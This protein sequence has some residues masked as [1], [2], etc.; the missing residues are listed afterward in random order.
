MARRR[1][2]TTPCRVGRG[3]SHG[4]MARLGEVAVAFFTT[5]VDA[6]G[7][8]REPPRHGWTQ[9]VTECYSRFYTEIYACAEPR[10]MPRASWDSWTSFYMMPVDLGS[11]PRENAK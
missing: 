11:R 6:G 5:E 1:M 10:K 7:G 4:D 8:H 9:K 2:A 3:A